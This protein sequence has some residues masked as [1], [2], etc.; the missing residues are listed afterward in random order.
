MKSLESLRWQGIEKLGGPAAKSSGCLHNWFWLERTQARHTRARYSQAAKRRGVIARRWSLQLGNLSSALATLKAL[1]DLI[2]LI[3]KINRHMGLQ[4]TCINFVLTSPH[5]T[6]SL[7]S[8]RHVNS[9]S[10]IDCL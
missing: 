7:H 6:S 8:A 9:T 3:D 4:P 10:Y 5:P 1:S 2:H